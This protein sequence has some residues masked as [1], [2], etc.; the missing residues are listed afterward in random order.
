MAAAVERLMADMTDEMALAAV[1]RGES[2][3]L[4]AIYQRYAAAVF[5]VIY[6]IVGNR[7][8]AE[9]LA[10]EA[11]VRVWLRAGGFDP[12]RGRPANWLLALARHLAVDWTRC[13][14]LDA[15][16][17][18]LIAGLEA[19]EGRASD[20]IA[21]VEEAAGDA[22]GGAARGHRARLFSRVIAAA[23]RGPARHPARHR[24]E[25]AQSR[26]APAAHRRRPPG[27]RAGDAVGG[28]GRL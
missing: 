1:A 9:E 4:E 27:A 16:S 13:R 2:E 12:A 6:R 25:P 5:S 28:R 26:S 18:R 19:L 20:P 17:H 15:R 7:P 23:D 10:Q 21:E 22:A 11:F 24:Q 14:R 3:A 8:V